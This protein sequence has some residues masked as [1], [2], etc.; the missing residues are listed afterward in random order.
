LRQCETIFITGEFVSVTGDKAPMGFVSRSGT[1]I[2]AAIVQGKT[3]RSGRQVPEDANT[4]HNWEV[5]AAILQ[6]EMQISRSVYCPRTVSQIR[7]D[8]D[9]R[10]NRTDPKKEERHRRGRRA[11]APAN[12]RL[13]EGIAK[14][15]IC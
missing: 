3:P 13:V 7:G 14:V 12:Q 6:L 1:Q 5:H 10:L 8:G 9:L 2:I 4:R 11:Q 15:T